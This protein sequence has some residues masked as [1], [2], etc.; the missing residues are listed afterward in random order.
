M[1]Y[2]ENPTAVGDYLVAD[3]DEFDI[4]ADYCGA[5]AALELRDP[6]WKALQDDSQEQLTAYQT[7]KY[8]SERLLY[9]TTY[10]ELATLDGDYD[11]YGNWPSIRSR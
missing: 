2:K 10:E 7:M 4:I 8:M 6:N 5:I 9:Q 3:T 1:A 11:V